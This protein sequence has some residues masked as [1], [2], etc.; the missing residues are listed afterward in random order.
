MSY[1]CPPSYKQPF[2]L[3]FI[4]SLQALE[5]RSEVSLEPSPLQTKQAQF[6]QPF[7]TGEV[8]QPSDHL[9]GPPLDLIQQVCVFPVLGAPGLDAEYP[10]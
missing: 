9:C 5:G 7:F 10:R 4:S 8:L 3:Q 6:H 2:P 1:H